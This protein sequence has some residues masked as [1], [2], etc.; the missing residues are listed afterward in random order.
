MGAQYTQSLTC[1]RCVLKT[2]LQISYLLE[3]SNDPKI[4]DTHWVHREAIGL[5]PQTEGKKTVPEQ[6][7]VRGTIIDISTE[8]MIHK[9]SWVGASWSSNLSLAFTSQEF[10]V[11]VVELE[12]DVGASKEEQTSNNHH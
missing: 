3:S 7:W 11:L 8:N 6:Y 5:E 10:R 12:E 9:K 4:G 2:C 1:I